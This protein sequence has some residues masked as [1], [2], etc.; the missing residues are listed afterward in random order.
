MRPLKAA[1]RSAVDIPINHRVPLTAQ[2]R[3]LL[4]EVGDLIGGIPVKQD[5]IRIAG[6][7]VDTEEKVSIGGPLGTVSTS[8]VN[9]AAP[10]SSAWSITPSSDQPAYRNGCQ[11]GP[12]GKG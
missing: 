1:D 2:L 7:F 12:D 3:C 11:H 10:S 4:K 5:G 9:W 8:P 6:S